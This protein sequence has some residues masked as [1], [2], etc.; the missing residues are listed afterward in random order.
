MQVS[1]KERKRYAKA[2]QLTNNQTEMNQI[3]RGLDRAFRKGNANSVVYENIKQEIPRWALQESKFSALETASSPPSE[4]AFPQSD[5]HPHRLTV[6][7]GTG[8]CHHEAHLATAF[9]NLQV[10]E[11]LCTAIPLLRCTPKSFSTFF[12]VTDSALLPL[13][14][15]FMKHRLLS[16]LHHEWAACKPSYSAVC[17]L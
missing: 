8:L 3:E 1:G 5:P 2:Y 7:W 11:Q 15:C 12:L 13:G 9:W 6:L 17:F 16:F 4:R 10:K 14:I